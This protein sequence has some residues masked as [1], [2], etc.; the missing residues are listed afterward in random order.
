MGV[1]C[2]SVTPPNSSWHEPK[3]AILTSARS[4]SSSSRL[5][6]CP[7]P[8]GL[9]PRGVSARGSPL[10]STLERGLKV[11]AGSSKGAS[12][13]V[14]RASR[15]VRGNYLEISVNHH[16][17]V[18]EVEASEQLS[19]EAA[20]AVPRQPCGVLAVEQLADLRAI[21]AAKA[22][23]SFEAASRPRGSRRF[24]ASRRL[25]GGTQSR[26]R[27]P[28]AANQSRPNP[29]NPNTVASSCHAFCLTCLLKAPG[30]EHC[31]F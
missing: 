5:S 8:Q 9:E 16:V 28:L 18:Q 10:R 23:G 1:T 12:R 11:A 30:F 3:S 7:P 31:G 20:Q 22:Q 13:K 14:Q 19:A 17:F 24:E 27:N 25:G 26:G 29:Q 2:E 6:H 21:T 15:K 4:P